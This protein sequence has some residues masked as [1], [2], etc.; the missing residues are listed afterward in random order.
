MERSRSSNDETIVLTEGETPPYSFTMKK[1]I[2]LL[3]LPLLSYS[4]QTYSFATHLMYWQGYD[5]YVSNQS[6]TF[7]GGENH[8]QS[9]DTS[10]HVLSIINPREN[11]EL[12]NS[13]YN[14][15]G[16]DRHCWI[17]GHDTTVEGQFMWIDQTPFSYS[18][19]YCDTNYCEPNGGT[20]ENYIMFN[21]GERGK[22]NDATN[23][24]DYFPYLF[25]TLRPTSTGGTSGGIGT[26][27]DNITNDVN[28]LMNSNSI[29]VYEDKL[30]DYYRLWDF[31]G[32][33]IYEGTDLNYEN[34]KGYYVLQTNNQMKKIF[35]KGF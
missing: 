26:L 5:Y 4:Q 10:I 31:Q 15:F 29:G 24:N 17:G 19:W 21:Y 30:P 32:N 35:V 2:L 18:N 6:F 33:L 27:N 7:W 14:L 22:W 3:L 13:I 16:Y 34:L 11:Y 9:M 28:N 8:I 12:A 1:L 20:Y 23:V 25:K